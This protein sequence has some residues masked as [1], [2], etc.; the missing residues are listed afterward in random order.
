MLS[1][2]SSAFMFKTYTFRR[3][4]GQP[5]HDQCQKLAQV[6]QN[7][8]PLLSENSSHLFA[9]AKRNFALAKIQWNFVSPSESRLSYRKF[10]MSPKQK[11][12]EISPK[13]H[14][15]QSMKFAIITFSQYCNHV[16]VGFGKMFWEGVVF[17]VFV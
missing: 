17:C 15:E 9:K 13:I 7:F 14:C 16:T 6:K 3:R 10:C 1:M 4:S 11:F 12:D 5:S 2:C 8:A